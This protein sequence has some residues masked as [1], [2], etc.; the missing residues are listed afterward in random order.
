MMNVGS[1]DAFLKS[2]SKP[3]AVGCLLVAASAHLVQ[4]QTIPV[5]NSSFESQVVNPLVFPVDFRL[6]S[7]QKAPQPGYFTNSPQLTWDQTVGL[8]NGTPAFSAN[9]YSN[10]EG[11]QAAYLLS[12]PQA[13]IFQDNLSTDWNNNTGG[14]S[15]TYQVGFAYQLTLGVF[16]KQMVENFSALQLSLYYRDGGNFVNVG[17]PTTITFNTITFDPAGPFTLIDYSVTTPI[18]Q[19]GDPWAGQNIGIR[20]ES[21]LGNGNGYWDMDNVRLTSVVPEPSTLSLFAIGAGGLLFA[22]VGPRRRS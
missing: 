7:W 22:V 21:L 3:V 12:L 13:G 6:D 4:A 1:A 14:L 5:S 16:G 11:N 10:L 8:F 20:I 18:V 2:L 17:S 9:P 19:P 15:A